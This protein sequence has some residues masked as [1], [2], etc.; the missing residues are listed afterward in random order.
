ME[1]DRSS[2]FDAGVGPTTARV[3]EIDVEEVLIVI[4]GNMVDLPVPPQSA[5]PAFSQSSDPRTIL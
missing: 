1:T 3:L 4:G 2:I 5:E